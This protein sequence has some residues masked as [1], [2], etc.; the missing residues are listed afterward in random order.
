MLSA[1]SDGAVTSAEDRSDE[2]QVTGWVDVYERGLLDVLFERLPN[3]I[4][5]FDDEARLCRCNATW[6]EFIGRCALTLISPVVKG[7]RLLD[8]IP[9]AEP[10]LGPVVE[11][12][13][14]GGTVQLDGCRAETSAGLSQW[15]EVFVPLLHDEQVVGFVHITI[16]AT[17]RERGDRLLEQRA[18]ER[19]LELRR[20]RDV[21]EA[22][23]DILT[24]LNSDLPHDQILEHVVTKASQ[25]LGSTDGVIYRLDPK[26]EF[27][28]SEGSYGLPQSSRALERIPL[29]R[30][31]FAGLLFGR[32][33]M[34]VPDLISYLSMQVP[35]E[36][37]V[38]EDGELNSWLDAIGHHYRAYLGVP[39][40]IK[41]QLYGTLGVYYREPMEFS[42]DDIELA[43]ALG[44]QV[45][46]AMEN[47]RLRAQAS[48][49]AVVAERERLARELH[50]SVTQSLY[51]LTL[52][53][54]ASQRLAGVGDL[55]PVRE[56][57]ARLGEIAQQALREMRLLVYQLRPLVLRR[58]GLVGALQQR[59]DAVEKR[60]GVDAR[61][62]VAGW[63]E[64]PADVEEG[65]YRIAQEALNNALK[66]AAPKT[67]TV[68]LQADAQRVRL[69]VCDDGR[70]FEP[71][72]GTDRG[73]MGL[74]NMRQRA[75]RLGG[76]FFVVST[77]GAGTTVAVEV[78]T[79]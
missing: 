37:G 73:G 52:L 43:V 74:T 41:E 63:R 32:E 45:A 79:F 19:R 49:G 53:A 29:L 31:R 77:V 54:E 55:E 30:D 4:A 46:L 28:S 7:Q 44:D 67:V 60:A 56:Y 1:E 17:E 72:R 12:V 15:D 10:R 62:L 76:S 75:E 58:E 22:L 50:D 33:P 23:G 3:G 34:V 2:S 14:A 35:Y 78:E 25:L 61:L 42:A 48:Q 20:R 39:L 65:L 36:A 71:E 47:A 8:L 57:T 18:E 16:D 66:H 9:H 13:L 6:A 68:E 21:V 51:S 70:G 69:E 59:L 27:V 64:L 5:V 40:V 11:R 38:V 24:V 26:G